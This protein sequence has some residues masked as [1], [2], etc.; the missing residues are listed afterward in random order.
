[1]SYKALHPLKIFLLL[2][3]LIIAILLLASM[4][5]P[6]GLRSNQPSPAESSPLLLSLVVFSLGYLLFLFLLFSENIKAV[7]KRLFQKN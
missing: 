7:T 1:M 2:L 3:P 4:I 5:S 6:D